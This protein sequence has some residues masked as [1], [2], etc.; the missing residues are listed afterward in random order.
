MRRMICNKYTHT[1]KGR[2]LLYV[3]LLSRRIYNREKNEFVFDRPLRYEKKKTPRIPK[4]TL[5][6]V[7]QTRTYIMSAG[8]QCHVRIQA[9]SIKHKA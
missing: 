8:A 5:S 3:G 2:I 7:E 6:F 4:A 9:T 1:R